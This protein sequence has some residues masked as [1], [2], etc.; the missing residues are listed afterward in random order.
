MGQHLEEWNDDA[1]HGWFNTTLDNP[2]RQ[3]PWQID[4]QFRYATTD[5]IFTIPESWAS[6]FSPGNLLATGRYRDGGQGG[7]GPDLIAYGPWNDGNPPPEYSALENTVLLQYSNA[8]DDPEQN[9]TMDNYSHADQW[10]GGSWL[11]AGDSSAVVFAGIKGM[12]DTWYGFYD[13]TVWPDEPPYPAPGPG[14]RGWWASSFD[15][16]LVFYDPDELGAVAQ[17][18]M[19]SWEPQP[20]ATLNINDVLYYKPTTELRFIGGVTFDR[21]N[22]YLYVAEIRG[23]QDNQRPLVHVWRIR[24]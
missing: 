17:D 11:T 23:D 3:G 21:D 2:N 1:S 9:N 13:G 20:Y 16:Q 5:Y 6:I 14:E 19:Q 7:Q 12:G 4:S 10:G 18:N 8:Y 22:G 15:G 24:K